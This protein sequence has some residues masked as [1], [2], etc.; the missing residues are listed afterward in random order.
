MQFSPIIRVHV[1]N[2][3]IPGVLVLALVVQGF[4]MYMIIGYLD[5]DPLGIIVL[6]DC[7]T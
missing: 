2:A 4:G 3:W 7:G 6:C 1:H 5:L